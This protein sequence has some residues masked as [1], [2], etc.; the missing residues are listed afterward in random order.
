MEYIAQRRRAIGLRQ[1]DLA[2]LAGVSHI[3]LC[4]VERGRRV[5]SQAYV[6]RV[7]AVLASY[8]QALAAANVTL[9][10]IPRATG[11]SR[12]WRVA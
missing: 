11:Q 5:P 2:K 1:V 10:R 4:L 9:A 7:E 6:R 8:E 3:T 12:T